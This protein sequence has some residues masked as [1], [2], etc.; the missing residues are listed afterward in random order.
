MKK[1]FAHPESLRDTSTHYCPGC[2]HGTVH[3]LIAE[4][5][6]ELAIREKVIGVAPVGCAVIAYDYWR[7]DCSE[8]AHGRYGR[9]NCHGA[10]EAF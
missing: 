7:F 9:G 2:G 1:I 10:G 8:A 3:R 6:D 5:V 4:I